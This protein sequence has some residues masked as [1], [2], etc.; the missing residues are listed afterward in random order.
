[1]SHGNLGKPRHFPFLWETSP[2]ETERREREREPDYMNPVSPRSRPTTTMAKTTPPPSP[3]RET[4]SSLPLSQHHQRHHQQR[5]Q[6]LPPL[7]QSEGE[8]A[9][10]ASSSLTTYDFSIPLFTRGLDSLSHLLDKALAF[11]REHNLTPHE[12]PEWRL[13]EDMLS[14]TFQVEMVS[15]FARLT[16]ERLTGKHLEVPNTNTATAAAI[17]TI[18][19]SPS[20]SSPPNTD[21]T[22][23][24]TDT[25]NTTDTTTTNENN[26]KP[27]E[28]EKE[29][30]QQTT[31]NQLKNLI[32]QTKTTI[33]EQT[34]RPSAIAHG[35]A[36]QT[37]NMRAGTFDFTPDQFVLGWSLP[38]FFFHLQTAYAILRMRGVEIGKLD[39]LSAF[40]GIGY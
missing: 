32:T 3:S 10:A 23:T 18:S 7:A 24:T 11:E 37:L 30:K 21:N 35:S 12:I 38:N 5:R 4:P 16:A 34:D 1:M 31:L 33:Q 39:Y 6:P 22:T 8:E 19:P 13:H 36:P 40:L 28:D 17:P 25:G 2:A 9:E 26:P 20:H 27:N 29:D 15:R 14:L